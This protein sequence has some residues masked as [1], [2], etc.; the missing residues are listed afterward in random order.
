MKVELLKAEVEIKKRI[1]VNGFMIR[2][3]MSYS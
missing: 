3:R 1:P 2:R